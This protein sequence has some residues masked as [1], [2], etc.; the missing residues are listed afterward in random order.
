[1]S[2]SGHKLAVL[3]AAVGATFSGAAHAALLST[4]PAGFT[5]VT[6]GTGLMTSYSFDLDGNGSVDF[7]LSGGSGNPTLTAANPATSGEASF[8]GGLTSYA[9]PSSLAIG[10]VK[11]NSPVTI[12]TSGFTSGATEYAALSTN[13]TF[14]TPQP[15]FGGAYGV[16]GTLGYI[17]GVLTSSGSGGTFQ[18]LDFG[19]VAPDTAVPEPASLALLA[20]GAAGIAALR[21]RRLAACA[22]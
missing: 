1:M 21:R 3:T 22:A 10:N 2:G 5:P 9:S 7:T 20:T 15:P 19:L 14:G 18:L 6:V 4:A 12:S 17:E 11:S 16:S 8:A 13:T